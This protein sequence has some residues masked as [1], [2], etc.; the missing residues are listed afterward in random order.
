MTNIQTD[1]PLI[2]TSGHK[3]KFLCDFPN[4]QTDSRL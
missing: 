4:D 2:E 1:L 3:Y